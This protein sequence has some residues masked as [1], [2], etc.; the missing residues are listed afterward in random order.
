MNLGLESTNHIAAPENIIVVNAELVNNDWVNA[1]SSYFATNLLPSPHV[2]N[3]Y[4]IDLN[5]VSSTSAAILIEWLTANSAYLSYED[6]YNFIAFGH[7]LTDIFYHSQIENAIIDGLSYPINGLELV[8]NG[9]DFDK[10][11]Y[12]YYFQI[13]TNTAGIPNGISA[14]S[15]YKNENNCFSFS[16]FKALFSLFDVSINY[17]GKVLFHFAQ[18]VSPTKITSIGF[19]LEY[20]TKT[21]YYDFSGGH[22]PPIASNTSLARQLK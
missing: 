9:K 21:M 6:S 18:I 16:L 22:Q 4:I 10:N 12:P 2:T 5:L 8:D 13:M 1:N 14:I 19:K 17:R 20:G 11:N 3:Y 7:E 15:D